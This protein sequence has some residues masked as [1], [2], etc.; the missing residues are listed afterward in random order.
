MNNCNA[1]KRTGSLLPVHIL[2]KSLPQKHTTPKPSPGLKDSVQYMK[3]AFGLALYKPTGV[4]K[5][6]AAPRAPVAF[7]L[8]VCFIFDPC[9]SKRPFCIRVWLPR[10]HSIFMRTSS[11]LTKFQPHRQECGHESMEDTT[12]E[13]KTR[14]PNPYSNQPRNHTFCSSTLSSSSLHNFHPISNGTFN[15]YPWH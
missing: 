3:G 9:K 15:L 2:A 5:S 8:V 11:I 10:L 6:I 1:T 13:Q 12:W 7:S 4:T 14:S